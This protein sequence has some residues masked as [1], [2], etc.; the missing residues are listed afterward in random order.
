ML[1]CWV[2]C[3]I[4]IVMCDSEKEEIKSCLIT[5]LFSLSIAE[6]RV[7]LSLIAETFSS[8]ENSRNL[9]GLSEHRSPHFTKSARSIGE[10]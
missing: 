8:D 1:N 4:S 7:Y 5:V 6:H 9:T 10:Y 3:D 2:T